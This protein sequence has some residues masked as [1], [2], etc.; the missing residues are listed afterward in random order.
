MEMFPINS[1]IVAENSCLDKTEEGSTPEGIKEDSEC[2]DLG[3]GQWSV[4]A[5]DIRFL[6]KCTARASRAL[7]VDYKLAYIVWQIIRASIA[8]KV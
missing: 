4:R 6:R 2:C 1:D 8:G 5:M 7:V 3:R